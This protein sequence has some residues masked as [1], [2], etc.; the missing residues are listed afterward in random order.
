MMSKMFLALKCL[1]K[2]E[3]HLFFSEFKFTYVFPYYN[4]VNKRE[5]TTKSY[6]FIHLFLPGWG[7]K[8]KISLQ[9]FALLR[10][11]ISTC[12]KMC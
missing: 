2:F 7:P 4:T 10:G 12:S 6:S 3:L 5:E 1:M 8:T 11:R 9:I